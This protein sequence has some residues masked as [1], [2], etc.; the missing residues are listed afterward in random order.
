MPLI[1][2]NYDYELIINHGYWQLCL[3]DIIATIVFVLN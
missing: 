3:I 1:S 2:I